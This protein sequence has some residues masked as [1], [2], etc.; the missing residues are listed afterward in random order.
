MSLV[1]ELTRT[2]Q[3]TALRVVEESAPKGWRA[4]ATEV[5]GVTAVTTPP[6]PSNR[7]LDARHLLEDRGYDPDKWMIVGPMS[8]C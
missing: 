5:D 7:E 1:E 3:A 8:C 4:G 2:Q 6:Y